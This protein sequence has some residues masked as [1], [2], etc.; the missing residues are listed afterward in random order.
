V[1]KEQ[2]KEKAEEKVVS[3]LIERHGRIVDSSGAPVANATIAIV[4]STVPMPEIALLSDEDGRFALRLPPGRFTF[5]AYGPEGGMGEAEVDGAP[6][7]DE[8]LITIGRF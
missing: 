8:I 2:T 5:R 6:E 4:A 1:A 3:G 7:A